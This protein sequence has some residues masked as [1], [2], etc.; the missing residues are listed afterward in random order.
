MNP[1]HNH[2][3]N[4]DTHLFTYQRLS[5]FV[6]NYTSYVDTKEQEQSAPDTENYKYVHFEETP[7][8][9]SYENLGRYGNSIFST[10]PSWSSLDNKNTIDA[11]KMNLVKL[12]DDY[13]EKEMVSMDTNRVSGLPYKVNFFTNSMVNGIP[14]IDATNLANQSAQVT[15][16]TLQGVSTAFGSIEDI[17]EF[18]PS[19]EQESYSASIDWNGLFFAEPGH[20]RFTNK[21]HESYCTPYVW[22]GDKAICEY[23]G[24]NA[25]LTQYKD[26]FEIYVPRRQYIPIRMQIY[27]LSADR[28]TMK[29]NFQVEKLSYTREEGKEG[30]QELVT[31]TSLFHSE[32][33]YL[34]N[35]AAFVSENI[36]DFEK[37]LFS[38]FTPFSVRNDTLVAPNKKQLELF[39][40]KLHENYNDVLA[41]KYDYN[42]D[43]RLSYGKIPSANMQYTIAKGDGI[44]FAYSMYRLQGDYRMGKTFQIK[45]DLNQSMA[46][47]MTQ[48]SDKLTQ[49]IL[50]YSNN[51]RE[52]PGY[53]PNRDSVDVQYYTQAEDKTGLECKELC[54]TNSNCRHYFTYTSNEKPKCIIDGDNSTP[55]YNRVPPTNS[56]H[57]I[58]ENSSSLFLRNYQLDID[59]GLHCGTF[60]NRGNTVPVEN[61]SNYSDT[62]QYAKY[63]VDKEPINDPKKIGMCGDETFVKHQNE[64]KDILY[65]DALYYADGSWKQEGF[66]NEDEVKQK[67]KTTNAIDDTGDAIKTNLENSKSYSKKMERI[68]ANVE[69]LKTSIPEFQEIRHIMNSNPKYDYHGDEL[70]YFRN[71][72]LPNVRKKRTLDSNE[73]YVNSQLLYALGTVT[74]AT[75]IVFAI[76]L[77]RDA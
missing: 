50:D 27:F 6:N 16:K 8:G 74:A 37:G 4:D 39:Y 69:E 67:E 44:P 2:N 68:Q 57:P 15:K 33:P 54:N 60:T 22:I 48:F 21:V 11:W 23:R 38:C 62:F 12:L 64:A 70:L 24:D 14:D 17:K 66:S 61:N 47:P 59:G 26:T 19:D 41:N 76:V 51:Y 5:D 30:Q 75:L 52:R 42:D 32:T 49:S 7:Q 55:H 35:Y 10:L 73:L 9:I 77:A 45:T 36:T 63:A 40:D 29:C 34:L 25:T 13:R 46:Y 65:K 1:S 43:N 20:Y 28:N 72:A 18:L 53:Y 56:E 3:S 71:K 31:S 58:D